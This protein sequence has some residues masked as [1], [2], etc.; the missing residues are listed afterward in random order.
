[1]SEP[2][3]IHKRAL[4]EAHRLALVEH[5]GLEG[6]RDEGLLDSALARP[7]NLYAYEGIEISSSLPQVMHMGFYGTMHFLT[8]TSAQRLS[9]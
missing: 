3:W 9:L 1:V 4:L 8:A 6:I 7:K 5:G 2:I